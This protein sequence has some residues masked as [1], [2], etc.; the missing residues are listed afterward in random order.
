MKNMGAADKARLEELKRMWP[1]PA[2]RIVGQVET[3]F[4]LIGEI[5]LT[6]RIRA[7]V[8]QIKARALAAVAPRGEVKP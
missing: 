7:Q 8:A 1:G 4:G 3:I 5:G 6:L 2:N